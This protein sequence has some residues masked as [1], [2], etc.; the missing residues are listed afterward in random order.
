MESNKANKKRA[1][2]DALN[3]EPVDTNDVD[4]R[5]TSDVDS[6]QRK[7]VKVK[8]RA[9]KQDPEISDEAE[10]GIVYSEDEFEEEHIVERNEDY[11]EEDGWEDVD[12]N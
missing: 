5:D 8:K 7:I 2:R 3:Q 12:S 4:M 9:Q 6:Q 11:G 1:G 10:G